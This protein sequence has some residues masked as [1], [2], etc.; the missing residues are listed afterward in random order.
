M[1]APTFL[2]DRLVKSPI[3]DPKTGLMSWDFKKVMDQ[4]AQQSANAQ[5]AV[6]QF[7]TGTHFN[8]INNRPASKLPA[9]TLYFETDRG[10]WYIN[11]GGTWQYFA[12]V[13]QVTQANLPTDLG[14]SDNGFLAEVTDFA[15]LLAW[16][17]SGWQWGPG[18]QGSGFTIDFT[19]SP[20]AGPS[21][22]TGWQQANGAIHVLTLQ[23]DGSVKFASMRNIAGSWYRQ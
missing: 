14:A 8:R 5:A 6:P 7:L 22:S 11:N 4:V 1:S 2:T 15:H 23:S 17:G 13:M 18:E 21:P 19:D 16:N 10:V 12:G 3:V 20:N 9:G